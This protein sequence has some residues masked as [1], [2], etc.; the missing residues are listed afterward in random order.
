MAE[1]YARD[2]APDKLTDAFFGEGFEDALKEAK[3]K[4]EDLVVGEFTWEKKN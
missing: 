4:G 2:I 1:V 3:E